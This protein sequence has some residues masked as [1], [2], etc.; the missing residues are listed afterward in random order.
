MNI[1]KLFNHLRHPPQKK[2]LPAPEKSRPALNISELMRQLTSD[3]RWQSR[4]KEKHEYFTSINLMPN[5]PMGYAI[6]TAFSKLKDSKKHQASYSPDN[7]TSGHSYIKN[8][9]LNL[10]AAGHLTP[11]IDRYPDK[12]YLLTEDKKTQ[13][14]VC[15]KKVHIQI[16][17][18][19]ELLKAQADIFQQHYSE[20]YALAEQNGLK[21][22]DVFLSELPMNLMKLTQ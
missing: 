15:F 17:A 1:K 5:D 12:L 9:S 3:E 4:K 6:M 21:A 7:Y 13:D 16:S 19:T 22:S 18:D 11:I 20:A 10:M 14:S 8:Q 2:S